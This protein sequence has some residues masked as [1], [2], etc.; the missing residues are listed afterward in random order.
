MYYRFL[1]TVAKVIFYVVR[2]ELKAY[3]QP[4]ILLDSVKILIRY[5]VANNPDKMLRQ[6]CLTDSIY[7]KSRLPNKH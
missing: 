2:M 1:L 5:K 4:R 7:K 6:Y 3:D